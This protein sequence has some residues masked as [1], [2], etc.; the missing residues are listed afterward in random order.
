MFVES[1]SKRRILF[2]LCLCLLQ[3]SASHGTQV[4]F[5]WR[6]AWP[7]ICTLPNLADLSDMHVLILLHLQYLRHALLHSAVHCSSSGSI[8]PGMVI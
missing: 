1:G 4:S 7:A 5:Q 2:L 3:V 8:L 6:D